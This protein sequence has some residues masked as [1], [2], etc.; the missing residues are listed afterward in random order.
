MPTMDGP[1]SFN[2]VTWPRPSSKTSLSLYHLRHAADKKIR[3]FLRGTSLKRHAFTHRTEDTCRESQESRSST[4]SSNASA[5]TAPYPQ[6]VLPSQSYSHLTAC[7]SSQQCLSSPSQAATPRRSLTASSQLKLAA[8]KNCFAGTTYSLQTADETKPECSTQKRPSSEHSSLVHG[9]SFADRERFYTSRQE[10]QTAETKVTCFDIT[11]DQTFPEETYSFGTRSLST[12]CAPQ[13]KP[14]YQLRSGAPLL[15]TASH[16]TLQFLTDQINNK[17]SVSANDFDTTPEAH[18]SAS[19]DAAASTVRSLSPPKNG[20][21][22]TASA[23]K[24]H[25]SENNQLQNTFQPAQRV[26]QSAKA[27]LAENGF[28]NTSACSLQQSCEGCQNTLPELRYAN[29]L[30]HKE[31]NFDIPFSRKASEATTI[32]TLTCR[33]RWEKAEHMAFHQTKSCYLEDG[34]RDSL[35]HQ[36]QIPVRQRAASSLRPEAPN[37]R[38][39]Q[40]PSVGS[41]GD[42]QQD[43]EQ[44]HHTGPLKNKEA[45]HLLDCGSVQLQKQRAPVPGGCRLIINPATG[46][47]EGVMSPEQLHQVLQLSNDVGT[48]IAALQQSK[49]TDISNKPQAGATS[50]IGAHEQHDNFKPI[51][52]LDK[53]SSKLFTLKNTGS[54]GSSTQSASTFTFDEP[55]ESRLH[56]APHQRLLE[57]RE[58]ADTTVM[59]LEHN[60]LLSQPPSLYHSQN[61]DRTNLCKFPHTS[62]LDNNSNATL[63]SFQCSTTPEVYKAFDGVSNLQILQKSS[64]S[65]ES[66]LAPFPYPDFM[67]GAANQNN[68]MSKVDWNP[69]RQ[70]MNTAMRGQCMPGGKNQD[71][72]TL[73]ERKHSLQ[74]N[75]APRLE[76]SLSAMYDHSKSFLK[77]AGFGR[78]PDSE[79]ARAILW[80]ATSASYQYPIEPSHQKEC[81]E[82]LSTPSNY[83]FTQFAGKSPYSHN[84][85]DPLI[86]FSFK[87]QQS[88]ANL[89]TDF[90][91]F[92]SHLRP[93]EAPSAPHYPSYYRHRHFHEFSLTKDCADDA[94]Y[95]YSLQRTCEG[96][97]PLHA[98]RRPNRRTSS[99]FCVD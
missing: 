61:I 19:F 24:V 79:T 96:Y 33:R 12:Y 91:P 56:T 84:C 26:S 64:V 95:N 80:H 69:S 83:N 62:L 25:A 17:E 46:E 15:E 42:Q 11:K 52:Q 93:A 75:H 68:M 35:A 70:E 98:Y 5:S 78:F 39:P 51:A 43:T 14:Q 3:R 9:F 74:L 86:N 53:P 45:I 22:Q 36:R 88:Y 6:Y 1:L 65:T 37:P 47:V 73:T 28:S 59:Q 60:S 71:V 85:Y 31:P 4:P 20:R 55:N 67:R 97:N 21:C 77:P 7:G 50:S 99:C 72:S 32:S 58:N 90:S 8:P 38:N 27:K 16:E 30:D 94:I 63:E 54:F 34:P 92:R 89:T 87:P 18:R 10:P 82:M 44:L 2:D 57:H 40:A 49:A 81:Y 23:F 13:H 76:S 48:H 41:C 66:L 29:L